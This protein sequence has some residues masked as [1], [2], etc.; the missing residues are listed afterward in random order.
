MAAMSAD[1]QEAERRVRSL[2]K[3]YCPEKEGDVVRALHSDTYSGRP[4]E[5]LHKLVRRFGPE[6]ELCRIEAA[7]L[8]DK[9]QPGLPPDKRALVLQQ[10]PD[11][12]DVLLK[13]L[14]KRFG[15]PHAAPGQ[16]S[17][18]VAPVSPRRTPPLPGR[19]PSGS[20]RGASQVDAQS[21]PPGPFGQDGAQQPARAGRAEA[22]RA[23]DTMYG[24]EYERFA[25]ESS[26][27]KASPSPR[28]AA[29][30]TFAATVPA[31]S[32]PPTE[33]AA[34][35]VS[36]PPAAPPEPPAVAVR[37]VSAGQHSAP[38]ARTSSL[39]AKTD[40]AVLQTDSAAPQEQS[41]T[42]S[43]RKRATIT[44]TR[45]TSFQGTEAEKSV[46]ALS[47]YAAENHDWVAMLEDVYR[48]HA[49]EKVATARNILAKYRGHE[50]DL[51]QALSRRYQDP[52][53]ANMV[54]EAKPEESG[55]DRWEQRLRELYEK[56]EPERV[57]QLPDLLK[58]YAGHEHSLYQTDLGRYKKQQKRV[59]K[60]QEAE[61]VPQHYLD[62]LLRFYDKYAPEK[63]E[64]AASVLRSYRGRERELFRILETIYGAS[65]ELSEDRDDN[66]S[67]E[68]IHSDMLHQATQPV[69]PLDIAPLLRPQSS[70]GITSAPT[71]NPDESGA[72]EAPLPSPPQPALQDPPPAR[73]DSPRTGPAL[74]GARAGATHGDP[75]LQIR[76]LQN[77]LRTAL[78][79]Q[80]G[81][82]ASPP[83]SGDSGLI[84]PPPPEIPGIP[85]PPP[86]LM[87]LP[88]LLHPMPPPPFPGYPYLTMPAGRSPAAVAPAPGRT[89]GGSRS[90]RG[91]AAGVSP[92]GAPP[93]L[94]AEELSNQQGRHAGSDRPGSR[95][96]SPR[97]RAGRYRSPRDRDRQAGPDIEELEP[98]DRP[99]GL[100]SASW[101][102]ESSQQHFS[103][104]PPQFGLLTG[105]WLWY[106]RAPSVSAWWRRGWFSLCRYADGSGAVLRWRSAPAGRERYLSM[107]G[108]ESVEPRVF[109]HPPPTAHCAQRRHRY[110]GIAV[111]L[112][113]ARHGKWYPQLLLATE[114]R[115]AQHQ[116]LVG[117]RHALAEAR[118]A[119]SSEPATADVRRATA[120]AR[121]W[122][123]HEP[124]VTNSGT[125]SPRCSRGGRMRTPAMGSPQVWQQSP[126]HQQWA[127]EA[128]PPSPD[129]VVAG[130]EEHSAAPPAASEEGAAPPATAAEAAGAAGGA[131]RLPTD[132]PE[133]FSNPAD[134]GVPCAFL[135]EGGAE[136]GKC[137]MAWRRGY[138]I[139]SLP[140]GAYHF[141]LKWV[142]RGDV[143]SLDAPWPWR[144][145]PG[146][147]RGTGLQLTLAPPWT[148]T[149]PA[150]APERWRKVFLSFRH[151]RHAE[152]L[153][154]AIAAAAEDPST[155][156]PPLLSKPTRLC[157]KRRMITCFAQRPA[158]PAVIRNDLA[159]HAESRLLAAEERRR[160]SLA[161]ACRS[162][163]RA[164]CG[165]G[166]RLLDLLQRTG[167]GRDP[168]TRGVLGVPAESLPAL[169][170]SVTEW[171][172]DAE[173][174]PPTDR[175]CH[176]TAPAS[177]LL[178][179]AARAADEAVSHAMRAL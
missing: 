167:A 7:R 83:R 36:P 15:E 70:H 24:A 114:S 159:G 64:G 67:E 6:P 147:C 172:G 19:R 63:K 151:R 99:P 120:A 30:D 104:P 31:S 9:H 117:L 28:E 69:G 1:L 82:S 12:P 29:R 122:D 111:T 74:D 87:P 81:R 112:G 57:K 58:A 131:A 77:A 53:I 176:F 168:A 41:E 75:A 76:V 55:D 84:S 68:S 52:A 21:E 25:Q 124:Q 4:F 93:G 47:G 107:R 145:P 113:G 140:R 98:L 62:M 10:H 23:V 162:S 150:A 17:V 78:A 96:N 89:P 143:C 16:H 86:P 60:H 91:P 102:G 34:A 169:L 94:P 152:A 130:Y 54:A 71:V 46:T 37:E 32:V 42:V 101:T 109:A 92:A 177:E 20:S 100:P 119:R 97:H 85:P 138:A 121:R 175:P 127:W 18:Y 157:R 116:W 79:L 118:F 48:R 44:R 56:H 133:G 128:P 103:S 154:R 3:R 129:G 51:F 142:S 160:R 11:Q 72:K 135:A 35:A 45:T 26:D 8:L 65:P 141:P 95:Q 155:P 161:A 178:R 173:D 144:V 73:G 163:L 33:A 158:P 174:A 39:V 40:S 179:E 165:G 105:C 149:G 49:P 2:M 43:K 136:W 156:A 148:A 27:G 61:R 13:R 5:L 171:L 153:L 106:R 108:A 125:P 132:L 80:R 22:E 38:A 126:A 139:V 164:A 50:Q 14:Q 134:E 66:T 110:R 59:R 146:W 170:D 88:T 137:T 115:E 166:A 123:S 90:P